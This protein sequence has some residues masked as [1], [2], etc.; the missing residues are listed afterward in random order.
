MR[1]ARAF[2][3]DGVFS[4]FQVQ[5]GLMMQENR[6][7]VMSDA[8]I[9][10]TTL[11]G[12]EDA[13]PLDVVHVEFTAQARDTEVPIRATDD[14]IRHAL[15]HAKVE[16]YT[17]IWSLVRRTGAQTKP[18]GFAVGRACPQCG[19]PLDAGEIIRCRYCQTLVC[20]G[21]HDWVLAE[22]TQVSEWRPRGRPVAG[23]DVLRSRDPGIAREILEDRASYLFW[24]WIQAGRTGSPA[25]L[26]KCAAPALLGDGGQRAHLA[27]AAAASDVA[28]G[29][30]DVVQCQLNGPDGYDRVTVEVFWSARMNGSRDYTP[31]RAVVRLARRTGARSPLSMTALVCPTCGAPLVDSDTTRCDHCQTELAAGNQTWVLEDITPSQ[32]R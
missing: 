28:V 18:D 24:K 9:L 23:F 10:R 31:S 2:V 29:G 15:A 19:A 20:S 3:S 14:Q 8:R 13:N 4:R 27:W 5:L 32:V 16:P 25:P 21:E 22:I 17:E 1:P 11:K 12:V 30:A 7:N 6:R 26:R